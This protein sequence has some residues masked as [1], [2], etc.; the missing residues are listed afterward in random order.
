MSL[1]FLPF[2]HFFLLLQ[3][4]PRKMNRNV[5][6]LFHSIFFLISSLEWINILLRW[7]SGTLK[8]PPAVSLTTNVRNPGNAVHKEQRNGEWEGEEMA[9]VFESLCKGSS[10]RILNDLKE[11]WRNTKTTWSQDGIEPEPSTTKRRTPRTTGPTATLSAFFLS[12]GWTFFPIW[13]LYLSDL[14][15]IVLG[16]PGWKSK[17]LVAY[18]KHRTPTPSL[19]KL[20][21]S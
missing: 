1:W 5:W 15:E 7:G 8:K 10:P 11:C 4:S 13:P 19:L 20:R 6:K 12:S 14:L 21:R 2:L 17:Y 16:L 3:C 9:N 18:G